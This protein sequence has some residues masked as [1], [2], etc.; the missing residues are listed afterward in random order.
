MDGTQWELTRLFQ[1]KQKNTYGSNDF[2]K[3]YEE[4]MRMLEAIE[5]GYFYNV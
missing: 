1:K 3:V 2:P 4:L 5:L